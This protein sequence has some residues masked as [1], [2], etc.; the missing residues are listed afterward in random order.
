[1]NFFFIGLH[2]LLLAGIKEFLHYLSLSPFLYNCHM[3]TAFLQ[4]GKKSFLYLFMAINLHET[5]NNDAT[6]KTL[7]Y[8]KDKIVQYLHKKK[9]AFMQLT[10]R[11]KKNMFLSAF[12]E[13]FERIRNFLQKGVCVCNLLSAFISFAH[14]AGH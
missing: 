1:M 14:V 3:K 9:N 6:K 2:Q 7:S 5:F 12:H 13:I 4:C 10:L 11:H 8:V